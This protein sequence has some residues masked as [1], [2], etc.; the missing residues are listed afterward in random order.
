[1]KV[2][3]ACVSPGSLSKLC[4]LASMTFWL[5][6]A[7]VAGLLAFA[8]PPHASRGGSEFSWGV[9]AF[10]AYLIGGMVAALVNG[11]RLFAGAMPL[12]LMGRRAPSLLISPVQEEGLC[13]D[14]GAIGR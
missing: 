4:L 3:L 9:A 10:V 1:M 6:V 12:R 5:P 2:S 11:S 13:R 8:D 7:L 14:S